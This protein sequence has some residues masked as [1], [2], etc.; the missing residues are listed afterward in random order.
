M[1]RHIV[2]TKCDLCYFRRH[3]SLSGYPYC[4]FPEDL[5]YNSKGNPITHDVIDAINNGGVPEGCLLRSGVT[6]EVE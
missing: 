5:V 6:F 3:D 2:V 4:D 1:I